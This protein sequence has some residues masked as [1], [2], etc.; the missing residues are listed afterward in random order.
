MGKSQRDKG[1]RGEREFAKLTGGSRI[2][3]SGAMAGEF[4][5]DV[6]LPN[7]WK[8]EVKRREEME[9]TLYSWILDEREKPDCVAFRADNKPWIVAMTLNKF[10]EVMNHE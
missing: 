4:G 10:M 1:L 5:N 3:L 7:G 9:K 6:K 8:V 2:P